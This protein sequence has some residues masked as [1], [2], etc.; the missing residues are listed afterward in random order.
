MSSFDFKPTY[1]G[2]NPS[3]DESGDVDPYNTDAKMEMDAN[4]STDAKVDPNA[5]L[6]IKHHIKGWVEYHYDISSHTLEW[7]CTCAARKGKEQGMVFA[8]GHDSTCCVVR[9]R[10]KK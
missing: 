1:K 5:K 9:P 7:K 6:T 3:T 2:C 10:S 4:L 8:P